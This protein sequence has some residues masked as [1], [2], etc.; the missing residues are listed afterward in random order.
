[1]N[2][3]QDQPTLPPDGTDREAFRQQILVLQDELFQLQNKLYADGRHALLIILQGLDASGKDGTIRNAFSC[4]NP[5]GVRVKAFKAPTETELQYDFLFRV[6]PHF[7]ERGMIQV[8]N[9]SYYEDVLVPMVTGTL[10]DAELNARMDFLNALEDHLSR[11]HTHI[12]KFYLNISPQE[13]LKRI[14]ER[15]TDPT[16]FWK[17]DIRDEET[18]ERW[19]DFKAAYDR[20]LNRCQARPWHI[21]PADRKWYRNHEVL[22]VVVECLRG[23]DLRYPSRSER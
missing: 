1:M 5:Q 23:L 14:E 2:L 10:P 19:T 3:L 4:F 8:F 16:K 6:Y 15:K 7:P 13:Q 18:A 21:I 12:L 22:R 20:V 9:R 17:Y 11:S